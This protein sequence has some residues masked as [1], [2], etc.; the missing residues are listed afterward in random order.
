MTRNNTIDDGDEDIFSD[1]D[2]SQHA[3]AKGFRYIPAWLMAEFMAWLSNY[4]KEIRMFRNMPRD[5]LLQLVHQFQADTRL[6]RSFTDEQW[7][8][9]LYVD[10]FSTGIF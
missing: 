6:G 3:P 10:D 8:D 5:K 7:L 1:K 2:I 9:D 4:H